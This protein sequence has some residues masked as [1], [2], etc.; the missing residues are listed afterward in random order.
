MS[1]N[2]LAE[3][4]HISRQSISKW[5]NGG[6]L[7]S[8]SNVVAISDLFEISL[9]ELIRGDEELMD[10]F[11]DDGK[12]RLTHVETIIFGGIGLGIVLLI[13]LKL[14]KIPNDIIEAGVLFVAFA[15]EL[16]IL[17][18]LEWRYVN[19]SLTKKAVF[20][21]V[22]VMAMTVINLLL[23]MWIGFTG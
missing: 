16:G 8:F 12:I 5:E 21:G 19:R 6:S 22:I 1:Q 9:D 3:K 20:F 4:L 2:D 13:I 10:K 18:N 15:G 7:P 14:F 17:M 23:S 11:K